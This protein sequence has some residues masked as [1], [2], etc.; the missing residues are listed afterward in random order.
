M[1]IA[2]PTCGTSGALL[3]FA[4]DADARYCVKLAGKLP[5]ALERSV[6]AY[7]AL[8]QPPQR[9]L[10]WKR[11]R[12]L[13]PPLIAAIDAGQVERHGRAW[14]APQAAWQGALDEM[15][16]KRDK[17]SLPLK[18]HG[19]LFEILAGGANRTEAQAEEAR[20]QQRRSGR[21]TESA[22]STPV[23]INPAVI[24]GRVEG[25]NRVRARMGQPP[26]TPD[27]EAAFLARQGLTT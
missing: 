9:M 7:L 24:K 13:L 20:E 1:K 17:L 11:V 15:V 21:Q 12:T 4:A 19:Y 16:D 6:W 23:R 25:E 14:A 2:C 8:F 18:S 3:L 10:T 26:M 27:E 22:P 5:P